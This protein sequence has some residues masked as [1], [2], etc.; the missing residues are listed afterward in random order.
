VQE[1]TPDVLD[2]LE[3]WGSKENVYLGCALRT[4]N[5]GSSLRGER[6]DCCAIPGLW[7]DIDYGTEHKKKNLPQ[8]EADA[9]ML[10]ESLGLAP[11]IIV[12]SGRGLQAWWKFKEPWVLDTDKERNTAEALTKGWCS[13]LRKRAASHG[14]D[15]D[16]V[17]DLPRVMR[18][19][20]LWN[21]KGVPKR[22]KILSLEPERIYN[23]TEFDDYLLNES[24]DVTEAPSLK[25]TFS[26]DLKA[27]PPAEKFAALLDL[28][29][30]FRLSWQHA[31]TDLQDQ[32]ASAYDLALATR[33]FGAGWGE[34]EVVNLLIAHRRKYGENIEKSMRRDYLERTLNKAM[35]G[36][37][38]ELRR[39][40]IEALKAG[41]Q[42]AD[43]STTDPAETLKVLSGAI[44]VRLTRFVRFRGGDNS[45]LLEADGCN[46]DI[47]DVE[48]LDSQCKFRRLILDHTDKRMSQMKEQNWHQFITRLFSTIENVQVASD[49]T[50]KGAY[51]NWIEL[52]LSESVTKEEDWER[53]AS[54]NQPFIKGGKR[55]IV[56]EG[57]RLFLYSRFQERIT[58][59]QL[60]IDLTKLG[61]Q[62]ERLNVHNRRKQRTKR[63]VWCVE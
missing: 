35:S 14:W 38:S 27:D 51:E 50:R 52:Y 16:Q 37:D 1:V 40:A 59:Q 34:Q 2:R 57:F 18:L 9:M 48:M 41:A 4:Q 3:K 6:K 55:Y 56:A 32:S 53:A 13:T 10:I 47:P 46:I 22:T 45:Y 33:A 28:D 42:T 30:L 11:T 25:W 7:L 58:S 12:H 19:P 39:E 29:H 36:K 17:G 15:A 26:L 21:R 62:Y 61:Y 54:D 23:P 31:R 63:S 24:S 49:S 8:T 43:S 20:G 44:G 5:F 60:T